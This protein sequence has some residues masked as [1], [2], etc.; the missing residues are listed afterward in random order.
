MVNGGGLNG[1]AVPAE[2]SE[3]VSAIVEK[4]GRRCA[5][6]ERDTLR[7]LDT[8]YSAA[9]R[10]SR[11]AADAEDLV[12]ETFAQAYASFHQV[13]EG[14]SVKPWLYRI[15]IDSFTRSYRHVQRGPWQSHAEE[16]EDWQLERAASDLSTGLTAADAE[17][18]ARLPDSDVKDA[19]QRIPEDFRMAVYLANVEGFS[20]AEIAEI[21]G[22][23]V[24]TV[25]SRLQLGRQELKTKLHRS[26]EA[27]AP[28][29]RRRPL[30]AACSD[31]APPNT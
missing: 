9:L 22:S 19:L 20:Y 2:S 25:K 13:E 6:F 11:N 29:Q 12:Q 31:A 27:R 30:R 18:L 10:I 16:V 21:M 3:R 14:A 4:A 17:A 23:S 5:A 7:Y 28:A 1:S 26:A 24:A 8:L 15:L